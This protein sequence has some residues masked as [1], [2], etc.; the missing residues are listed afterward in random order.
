[1]LLLVKRP[2]SLAEAQAYGEPFP[3]TH[4]KAAIASPTGF[5]AIVPLDASWLGALRGSQFMR[6]LEGVW[7]GEG[8][9]LCVCCVSGASSVAEESFA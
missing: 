1:M 4:H 5:G 2:L 6:W 9:G 7:P 3:T 8:V